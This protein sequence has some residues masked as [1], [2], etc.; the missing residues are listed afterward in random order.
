MTPAAG[1]SPSVL[2]SVWKW[3][4]KIVTAIVA[5]AAFFKPLLTKQVER[6]FGAEDPIVATERFENPQRYSAGF[7]NRTSDQTLE[8]VTVHADLLGTAGS[9]TLR[10]DGRVAQH[11]SSPDGKPVVLTPLVLNPGEQIVCEVEASGG[12]GF[13]KTPLVKVYARNLLIGTPA[14][15]R[16]RT[17]RTQKVRDLIWNGVLVSLGVLCLASLGLVIWLD[18]T[19]QQKDQE[20]EDERK[21]RLALA[22][23]PP[24][25]S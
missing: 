18:R 19:I 5:V 3:A 4:Y 9:V 8:N 2:T 11:V 7:A 12:A 25:T 20:L 15:A 21:L 1:S 23:S 13:P 17:V 24:S 16:E 6:F 10:E 14:D 22:G